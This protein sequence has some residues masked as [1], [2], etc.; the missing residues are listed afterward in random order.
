MKAVLLAGGHGTR[1]YP[2]TSVISKQLLPVYDK[3]MIY[4]P[5]S[6]LMLAKFNEVLVVGGSRDL[7]LLRALLGNGSQ[8]GMSISY[9][10]QEAP[11]GIAQA[12]V[13]AEQF[14]DGDGCCLML[15]DNIF[16][17]SSL[18]AASEKLKNL[19]VGAGVFAYPVNEPS[20]YGVITFEKNGIATSIEEKPSSPKSRYAVPGMYFYDPECVSIAKTISK[21]ARG[22]FE[23]TSVN[24]VYLSNR[25]L[26]V[27]EL[28]RGVTWLDAGTPSS[29]LEASSFVATVQNRQGYKVA[30]LEEIAYRNQWISSNDLANLS[31]SIPSKEYRDYLCSLIT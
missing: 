14:L 15:G 12:L 27:E 17:G 18:V 19:D 23:I 5:L 1:L 2:L 8:L 28:G 25:E 30:C 22:E 20:R 31:E 9:T 11:D 3:P 29:L 26:H 6:T 16:Y 24:Q 13:L 4:Y 7:P 21:S 10:V